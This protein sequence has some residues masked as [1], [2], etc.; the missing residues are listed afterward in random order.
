MN[1]L[2][3]GLWGF[4]TFPGLRVCD[5]F[6]QWSNILLYISRQSIC[7][8]S[9]GCQSVE[10]PAQWAWRKHG[11]DSSSGRQEQEEECGEESADHGQWEGNNFENMQHIFT[12]FLEKPWK[13]S[14]ELKLHNHFKKQSNVLWGDIHAIDLPKGLSASVS[15]T[16]SNCMSL[17]GA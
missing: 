14:L 17:F 16:F 1:L 8:K 12:M 5:S 7:I 3:L 2:G 9:S 11:S 15:V 4:V 10:M 13:P 6:F